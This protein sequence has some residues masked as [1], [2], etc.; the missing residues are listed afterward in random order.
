MMA[1]QVSPPPASAGTPYGRLLHIQ[2]KLPDRGLEDPWRMAQALGLLR[3]WGNLKKVPR[4]WLQIALALA[5]DEC[6]TR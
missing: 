6:T 4:S 5:I 2:I 1:Q 3:P